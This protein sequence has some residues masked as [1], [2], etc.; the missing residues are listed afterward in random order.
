M[1]DPGEQQLDL[2]QETDTLMEIPTYEEN[3]NSEADLNN[4]Q[5]LIV[6]NSQDEEV[7]Q[8]KEPTSTTDGETDPQNRDQRKRRDKHHVQSVDSSHISCT[9]A[10]SLKYHM[11]TH[12]GERPYSC[13]KCGKRFVQKSHVTCHMLSHT[14]EKPYSCKEC[15][16]CFRYSSV[17]THHMYTHTG[18]KP[19]SCKE[20]KMNFRKKSH[21]SSH[22]LTHTGEKPY[23]CKECSKSFTQRSH[24]TSHM[25]THTG[26]KPYSCNE[27]NMR[28]RYRSSNNH[29][30][31]SGE[32]IAGITKN[33]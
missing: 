12:T 5:S 10:Q 16:K 33:K 28:F 32:I 26:E 6:T 2:K 19:F 27:C 4:Q 22:M 18:E 20:C 24:L 11:F 23:S 14:G 31:F 17:L 25:L 9:T 7:N 29:S 1:V 13:K 3:E 21:L 30:S 15:N 8:H